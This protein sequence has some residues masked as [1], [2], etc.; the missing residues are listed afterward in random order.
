MANQLMPDD[1][2]TVTFKKQ[3]DGPMVTNP[4]TTKATST[5]TSPS[6]TNTPLA[7]ANAQSSP[8]QGIRKVT[9]GG[10]VNSS[11]QQQQYGEDDEV[12]EAVKKLCSDLG[13]GVPRY[14]VNQVENS[15]N[16]F[17]GVVDW[18]DEFRV[19]EGVGSVRD[20]YGRRYVLT[21]LGGLLQPTDITPLNPR[22]PLGS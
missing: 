5:P 15:A 13:F 11:Q 7:V 16:L 8:R 1:G 18:G 6:R 22:C 9:T 14:I 2:E 3:R 10:K 17:N 20:I 21:S 4:T 19:P 12:F